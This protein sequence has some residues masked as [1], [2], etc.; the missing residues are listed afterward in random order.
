[1]I[2]KSL[3]KTKETKRIVKKEKEALALKI[4]I[5]LVDGNQKV[6]NVFGSGM[7]PKRK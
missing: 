7:F 2:F 3:K 6:L 4:A 5:I 1:M